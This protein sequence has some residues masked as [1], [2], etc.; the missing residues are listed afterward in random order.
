MLQH[1]MLK[2]RTEYAI[3]VIFYVYTNIVESVKTNIKLDFYV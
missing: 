3:I 2:Q 1:N